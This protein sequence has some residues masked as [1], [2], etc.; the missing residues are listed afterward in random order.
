[1][2]ESS[3]RVNSSTSIIVAIHALTGITLLHK[4]RKSL[5]YHT[6]CKYIKIEKSKYME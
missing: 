5:L 3:F 2:Y 6:R 4:L 1:M